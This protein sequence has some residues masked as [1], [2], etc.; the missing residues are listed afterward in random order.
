MKG[1]PV[2]TVIH[3][4]KPMI[5]SEFEKES[6]AIL[7]HFG[8]QDDAVFELLCGRTVPSGLLP[9]RM[10]KDMETIE[11]HSEDRPDD[12]EAFTDSMGN[13]YDFGF[14]MSYEAVIYDER[15]KK[16]QL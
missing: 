15:N 3:A 14:G 10:P 12:Y 11:R 16:Y 2:I 4:K 9:F 6:D 5:V 1:K 7:M 8:I 13:K